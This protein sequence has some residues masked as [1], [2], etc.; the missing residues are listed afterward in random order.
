MYGDIL[1]NSGTEVKKKLIYSKC[2]HVSGNCREGEWI[3][4]PSQIL[5]T[6]QNI[7]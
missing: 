6:A 4:F 3:P 7:L 5:E 1:P 2:L